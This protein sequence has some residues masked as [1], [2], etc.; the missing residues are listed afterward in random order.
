[1]VRFNKL[2]MKNKF[3]HDAIL[4]CFCT[5]DKTI[6][7]NRNCCVVGNESIVVRK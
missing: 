5:L 1:M 7:I 3:M 4:I 6:K 2:I